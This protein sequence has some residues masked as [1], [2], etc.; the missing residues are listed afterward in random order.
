VK[1]RLLIF[2]LLA[3]FTLTLDLWSKSAAFSLMQPGE[4]RVVLKVGLA[5]CHHVNQ[6]GLMGVFSAVQFLLVPA[7][8]LVAGALVYLLFEF[9]REQTLSAISLGLLFGGT[10][11]NFYDR[12]RYHCVR[13]WVE[14]FFRWP[15]APGGL[16]S[17]S[18]FNLADFFI[19][20][21]MLLFFPLIFS[22]DHKTPDANF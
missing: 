20:V 15:D 16:L 17:L 21:A 12:L 22:S 8:I 6:G 9:R 2:F 13:D 5:F 10:L 1:R 4:R 14:L 3:A 18:I 11:G 7:I 19:L